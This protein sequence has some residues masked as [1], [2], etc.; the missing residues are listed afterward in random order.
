MTISQMTALLNDT[1]QNDNQPD[2]KLKN[3]GLPNDNHPKIK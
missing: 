1:E 3:V 2:G